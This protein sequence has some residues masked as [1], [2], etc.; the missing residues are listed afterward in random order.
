MARI[1]FAFGA[2]DRLRMACQV[3]RKHYL[4]GRRLVVYTKDTQRLNK[5]DQL[6][7]SFE[8][9]EFVPHVLADDPLAAQT[10]VVLTSV[11]PLP[12]A[13]EKSGPAPWL[14]NLDM[15]CPPEAE[16]FDR[17]LEIV[18]EHDQDK[19]AAR[20]RWRQY[21]AAGHDLHAHNVSAQA[22]A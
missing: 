11:L 7:W 14:V 18:S 15:Q 5:F 21:Q 2:S 3:V 8:P 1:D 6:L 9:T 17:I 10:A 16:R 19:L 20:E 13:E 4:A 22:K 12:F